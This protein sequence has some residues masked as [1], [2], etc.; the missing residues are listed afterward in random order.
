MQRKIT[1][2]VDKIKPGQKISGFLKEKGY[3]EQNLVNLKKNLK[4]IEVNDTY[5]YQ[6]YVLQQGDILNVY[7]R[8]TESSRQIIPV[9]LPIDIVYEDEDLLVVNKPAGMPIHPSRNNPDNSLGNALAWYYKQK[10][11]A[12][13][14]RCIN[15]LDRDTSGLT[16]VAKHMVS[17]AILAQMVAAK[18]R[19]GLQAQGIHR[20]Y[21]AIVEGNVEPAEGV[22]DAPIARKESRCLERVVDYEK[23]DRA[24]T[25][26]QKLKTWKNARSNKKM[27]LVALQ[28]ETGRTHQ[29]RV[30]MAY[31]GHP[32]IGDFLYNP[33]Y[34]ANQL[35]RLAHAE[36]N[37]GQKQKEDT[38]S[39][40]DSETPVQEIPDVEVTVSG[41]D[42]D[43]QAARELEEKI[44]QLQ[45]AI[46]TESQNAADAEKWIA[47]MK[48]CVNPTE[49]TAELLNTLIEK[50]VV[51]E[52]VK[53]EDGS[54]EQEVEIFY[55]FIGKI[56]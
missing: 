18:S 52:A 39:E 24:I 51:H 1:Y 48:E 17:G 22:I 25:H 36:E 32:L 11:Q 43:A 44:E 9:E 38:N 19:D 47:L 34:A 28:L 54:R 10:Q 15:R 14:F 13:V 12:F 20:E 56:D 42:S 37:G 40:E 31:L 35:D 41:E 3:S 30:H 26:Y 55:R 6:N 53:G 21:L 7:I 33:A 49:L 50:I 16:I 29:I 5:V 27:S 4:S 2:Y 45:S 46:A 23:G 8:E